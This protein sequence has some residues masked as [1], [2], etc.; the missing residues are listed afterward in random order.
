MNHRLVNKYR[1]MPLRWL[2]ELQECIQGI[3][4]EME[5]LPSAREID[6]AA[7]HAGEP[8]L[9]HKVYR[10]RGD[11][12]RGRW[13]QLQRIYC[14]AERCAN[15]PHGPY[16]YTYRTNKKRGTLSV[17]FTGKG[18]AFSPELLEELERNVR[19]PIGV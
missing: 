7:E 13:S 11:R 10:L 12:K 16:W 15:C 3:I 17:T 9:I 8:H 1:R 19:P 14:S 18:A 5:A 4:A 2:R 6:I